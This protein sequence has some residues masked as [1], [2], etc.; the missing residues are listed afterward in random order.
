MNDTNHLDLWDSSCPHHGD[1]RESSIKDGPFL[2]F[3]ES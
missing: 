3:E 2:D 1:Q